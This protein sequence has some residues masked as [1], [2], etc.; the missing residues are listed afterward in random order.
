[1]DD[2]TNRAGTDL[3]D[4]TD[5]SHDS[6]AEAVGNIYQGEV[7]QVYWSESSGSTYYSDYTVDKHMFLEGRVLW[8]RG[9][10]L[11][12]ECLHKVGDNIYKKQILVN[13]YN[14]TMIALKD[15][16]NLDIVQYF[17]GRIH[18]RTQH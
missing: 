16:N 11:A 9:S 14:V 5:S 15:K 1:M 17:Q 8:G 4:H 6:I 12:L 2:T 18:E 3:Q 7:V 10:V 13:S